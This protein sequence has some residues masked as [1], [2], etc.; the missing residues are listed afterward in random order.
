MANYYAH[1]SVVGANKSSRYKSEA[2]SLSLYP[3]KSL[4]FHAFWNQGSS[5]TANYYAHNPVVGANKFSRYKAEAHSPSF[6][7][8]KSLGS[9]TFSN[10]RSPLKTS[11]T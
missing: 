6:Y 7:S 11:S 10:Q 1:N 4:R 2:H 3:E 5:N 9:Q 8:E